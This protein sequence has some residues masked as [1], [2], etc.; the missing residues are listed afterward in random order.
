MKTLGYTPR[1]AE[2]LKHRIDAQI[3]KI[4][5]AAY[6]MRRL[7]DDHRCSVDNELEALREIADELKVIVDRRTG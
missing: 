1:Q 5:D 7:V 2:R 4:E 6:T 3:A